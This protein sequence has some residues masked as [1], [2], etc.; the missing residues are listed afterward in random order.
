MWCSVSM[1]VPKVNFPQGSRWIGGI[2]PPDNLFILCQSIFNCDISCGLSFDLYLDFTSSGIFDDVIDVNIIDLVEL[3][4]TDL[5]RSV[6]ATSDKRWPLIPA[7]MVLS[8]SYKHSTFDA[9]LKVSGV[10]GYLN[11]KH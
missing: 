11:V 8:L 3:I 2:S 6:D 10:V 7:E 1:W 4:D 9:F 5:N